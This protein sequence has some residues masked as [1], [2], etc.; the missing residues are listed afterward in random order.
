M[1][2]WEQNKKRSGP[3][4][5]K[6][7]CKAHEVVVP[8][9]KNGKLMDDFLSTPTPV[10]HIDEE[11]IKR[12]GA[13]GDYVRN[14]RI[15]MGFTIAKFSKIS[16]INESTMRDI[17]KHRRIP[18][19]KSLLGISKFLNEDVEDLFSRFRKVSPDIVGIICEK[20]RYIPD[21][22]R[23]AKG[24]SLNDWLILGRH[25]DRLKI[26]SNNLKRDV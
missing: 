18:T 10:H 8:R 9:T 23:R 16:G 15:S 24:L 25:A 12:F 11:E 13:R 1:A 14:K 6:S 7:V 3:N 20:Y 4:R 19:D 17:E 26:I 5:S 2:K 21:F 22:L